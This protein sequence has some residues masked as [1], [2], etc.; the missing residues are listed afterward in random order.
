MSDPNRLPDDSLVVRGGVATAEQ[1]LQGSRQRTDLNV[2]GFSVQAF[3]G[4]TALEL[5]LEGEIPH[6]QISVTT[7]REIRKAG[8]DIIRTNG[9]GLHATVAVPTDWTEQEAARLAAIFVKERNPSLRS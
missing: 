5:V 7:V 1:L 4:K 9:P 8:Y 2:F 3:P 6:R